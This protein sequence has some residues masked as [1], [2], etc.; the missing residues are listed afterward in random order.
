MHTNPRQSGEVL[1]LHTRQ[2]AAGSPPQ[3]A[4]DR[5]DRW[6]GQHEVLAITGYSK[7]GIFKMVSEGRFPKP[8]KLGSRLNRWR[9]SEVTRWCESFGEAPAQTQEG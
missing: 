9:L 3:P 1:S 4:V 2:A 5:P 8:V 7:S 6:I